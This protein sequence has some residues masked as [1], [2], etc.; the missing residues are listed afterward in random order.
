MLHKAMMVAATL[1]AM[2]VAAATAVVALAFALFALLRGPIGPAGAAACVAAAAA[3][4]IGVASLIAA[5]NARRA[6]RPTHEP[7]SLTHQLFELV[8]DKPIA[9]GGVAVGAVLMA[10]RNPQILGVLLRTLIEAWPAAAAGLATKAE[11]PRKK[12]WF[13]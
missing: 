13:G 9:S 10:L 6:A 11:P 5:G 12:G 8:K 2:A 3:V 7:A 4:S 1:A